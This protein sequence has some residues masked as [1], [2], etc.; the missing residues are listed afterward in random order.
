M[1]KEH[2]PLKIQKKNLL[3]IKF[4]FIETVLYQVER[5]E[6]FLLSGVRFFTRSAHSE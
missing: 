2:K 3:I 6:L 1:I 4:I 5:H